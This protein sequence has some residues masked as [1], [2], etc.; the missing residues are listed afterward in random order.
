MSRLASATSRPMVG[1]SLLGTSGRLVGA[2]ERASRSWCLT[3]PVPAQPALRP[4]HCCWRG[5][6]PQPRVSAGTIP[7]WTTT[8]NDHDDDHAVPTLRRAHRRMRAGGFPGGS[9]PPPSA[10]ASSMKTRSLRSSRRAAG[11][12]RRRCGRTTIARATPRTRPGSHTSDRARMARSTVRPSTRKATSSPRLAIAPWN[13]RISRLYGARSSPT[14]RLP[15]TP[16]GTP[17]RPSTVAGRTAQR[18]ARVRSG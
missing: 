13:C 11:T 16:R 7:P 18:A 14:A 15:R 17:S 9:A 10:A 12:G 4:D 8:E 6:Q 1:S 5:R 2:Q 3:L